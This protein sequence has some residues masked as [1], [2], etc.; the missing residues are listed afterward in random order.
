MSTKAQMLSLD[1]IVGLSIIMLT[2]IIY[3]IAS[4]QATNSSADIFLEEA[5]SISDNL[6]TAGIPDY[7]DEENVITIGLTDNNHIINNTKLQQLSDMEYQEAKNKLNI[8]DDFNIYIVNRDGE[9]TSIQES[10]ELEQLIKVT[11]L[12]FYDN[13]L[14]RL[15]IE[16]GR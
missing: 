15:T 3:F 1:F 14:T 2:L 16:V 4:S 13:D 8:R 12:V 9:K 11:R 5:E 6:I 7:W 10:K